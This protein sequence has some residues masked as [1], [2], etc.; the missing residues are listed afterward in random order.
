RAP[1]GSDRRRTAL[2]PVRGRVGDPGDAARGAG[3]AASGPRRGRCGHGSPRAARVA[4]LPAHRA[5]GVGPRRRR[6]QARGGCGHRCA[7]LVPG[8]VAALLPGAGGRPAQATA[9]GRPAGGADRPLGSRPAGRLGPRV[10]GRG[11]P[12]RVAGTG[13]GPAHGGSSGTSGRAG[14]GVGSPGGPLAAL[15]QVSSPVLGTCPGASPSGDG[16]RGDVVTQRGCNVRLPTRRAGAAQRRAALRREACSP[17]PDTRRP[18]ARARSSPT[19][20]VTTTTSA[21]STCRRS[22][23]STSRIRVR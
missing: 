15:G 20:P 17:G 18:G 22:G 4:S 12:G 1:R 3:P 14:G 23:G 7:G 9:R 8:A 16:G 21:G 11:R 19:S 6:T 13:G 2:R 10:V 5:R